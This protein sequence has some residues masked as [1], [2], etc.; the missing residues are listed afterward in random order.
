M[1]GQELGNKHLLDPYCVLG[2]EVPPGG[3]QA[4][5]GNVLS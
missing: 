4:T 3:L 1:K 5:T 2:L